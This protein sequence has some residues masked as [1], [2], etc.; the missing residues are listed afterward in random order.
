MTHVFITQ[1]LGIVLSTVNQAQHVHH[2]SD[3]VVPNPAEE[4]IFTQ[5]FNP[6]SLSAL[7]MSHV[8]LS[9][10]VFLITQLH[11]TRVFFLSSV[12]VAVAKGKGLT[13]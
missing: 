10:Y 1:V 4:K 5:C 12:T 2:V 11:T 9:A 8:I 3:F 13:S 6:I 7:L